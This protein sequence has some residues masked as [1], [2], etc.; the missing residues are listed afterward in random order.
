MEPLLEGTEG[1][2]SSRAEEGERGVIPIPMLMPA[3]LDARLDEARRVVVPGE[4]E[5]GERDRFIF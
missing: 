1:L 4:P 2:R 5:D 3:R